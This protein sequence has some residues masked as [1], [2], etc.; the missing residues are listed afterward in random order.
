[1]LKLKKEMGYKQKRSDADRF[2]LLIPPTIHRVLG[3]TV[4]YYILSLSIGS[5]NAGSRLH[6]YA[7]QACLYSEPNECKKR[8]RKAARGRLGRRRKCS[9]I[10]KG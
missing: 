6:C 8:G 4:G 7:N 5:V 3:S 1:M 9:N 2:L 10:I